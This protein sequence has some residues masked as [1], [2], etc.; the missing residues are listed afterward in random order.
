[1]NS[2]YIPT[3][4]ELRMQGLLFLGYLILL[5]SEYS[6]TSRVTKSDLASKANESI[7]QKYDVFIKENSKKFNMWLQQIYAVRQLEVLQSLYAKRKLNE[8]VDSND[9]SINQEIIKF[10]KTVNPQIEEIALKELIAPN[11]QGAV[12]DAKNRLHF[13]FPNSSVSKTTL[14]N[15]Y[16]KETQ[17]LVKET[18]ASKLVG[19]FGQ[20]LTVP[21]TIFF[22]LCGKKITSEQMEEIV[23]LFKKMGLINS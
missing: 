22:E 4:H 12:M 20:D 21:L 1:M 7:L 13:L 3:N 23:S 17:E 10:A 18:K 9:G 8:K 19:S 15:D 6:D 16:V 2:N 14:A 11:D 5:D